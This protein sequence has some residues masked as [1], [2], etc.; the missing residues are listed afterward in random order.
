MHAMRNQRR[1]ALV[2]LIGLLA[3]GCGSAS[4]GAT[5][6]AATASG[7]AGTTALKVGTS[8]TLSNASLYLA[9]G[10]S[11]FKGHSLAVTTTPESSGAEAVPQLLNGQIQ[12]TAT[13]PLGA[14]VAVSEHVP[15]VIVAQA[16]VVGASAAQDSTGLVVS[17]GSG[18]HSAASLSGKTIAVNALDSISEVTAEAA[19]DAAGG[20]SAKVKFVELPF[21][22]MVAAVQRG[23]VS[24]AMLGE[25]YL[26]QAKDA[27]LVDLFPVMSKT[28]P[29]TPQLVYIASKTYATSHPA[30]VNAFAASITAANGDLSRDPSLIRSVGVKST[31]VG[32][33]VLARIILPTFTPA[34][35]TASSLATLEQLMIRYKVLKAPLQSSSY[36][37]APAG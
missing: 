9:I 10:N 24:G 36:M 3:A 5:G 23:L 35:L 7:P 13:D 30:I 33:S 27:G 11:L 32:A 18:I 17:V 34:A 16:N 28:I 12:F 2:C 29:G 21:P 15:V 1:L 22:Q 20:D 19:I 8:P 14:L 37:Y 25:P 26:T 6:T 31:T 4:E